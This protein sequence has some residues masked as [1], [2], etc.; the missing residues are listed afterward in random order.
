MKIYWV[1]STIHVCVHLQALKRK[2]REFEHEMER[3][4]KE[5]IAKQQQII[6]LRRELSAHIDN[7]DST[8]MLTDGEVGNSIRER[9]TCPPVTAH[10][11]YYFVLSAHSHPFRI[12]SV[13]A[14]NL[15]WRE[16]A[17]WK[18]KQNPWKILLLCICMHIFYCCR[19][20][21]RLCRSFFQVLVTMLRKWARSEAIT[22]HT[23]Q[24][25]RKNENRPKKIKCN[26][27]FHDFV[28]I[29]TWSSAYCFI[30]QSVHCCVTYKYVW[31]KNVFQSQSYDVKRS[32]P[33]R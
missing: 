32:N 15:I 27:V 33:D 25:I 10:L 12:C 3:L 4:A 11:Q 6:L 21:T 23:A 14:P 22:K 7:F 30:Y 19:A 24:F 2:E 18:K 9:G 5:K 1:E 20:Q 17:I 26:Y 8:I 29:Y 28:Y 13:M 31:K 16:M